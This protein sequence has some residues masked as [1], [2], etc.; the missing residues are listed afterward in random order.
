[1]H[2]HQSP[3][4]TTLVAGLA[5]LAITAGTWPRV[6]RSQQP[7]SPAPLTLAAARA[8]ARRASPD[9]R[10][11]REAVAA[12]A[13]RESQSAALPN[14]TLAYGREQTSRAGRTN[15]QDIGQLEQPLEVGGQRAA[16]RDAARLRRDA[17]EARL[18]AA[19]AQLDFDVARSYAAAVAAE[20]RA[21]LAEQAAGAFT[22]AE[23]VSDRRLAAGDLSGYAARRLRLE[24]A[25]YASLR[26]EAALARR[27]TRV[28]LASLLGAQADSLLLPAVLPDSAT[29][30]GRSRTLAEASLRDLALRSRP[31]LRASALEAA[32]AAAD[33][34]L[35]ARERIPS[36]TLSAGVK[37]E[38]V[39]DGGEGSGATF[40]GF[41][42][43]LSVPLPLFDRRRGAVQAAAAETRRRQAEADALRVRVARE[44]DEA[45]E[46]VRAI[47]VQ[48]EALRPQLGDQTR[49][50]MRAVQAAY[51]EGEITLVEWLDAVRAYQE[52]ES[53]Y[54]T[55]LA[56]AVVRRA[57]LE[58]A[59]GAS[60]TADG[61]S[62]AAAPKD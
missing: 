55:L 8:A 28:A 57:A 17:A 19:E 50:A 48:L 6:L 5:L 61:V 34:R 35:A 44:V 53:T 29:E 16:R 10:A 38:R 21:T 33:A 26:A 54:A 58:R 12:A 51:S 27:T 32:A 37:R 31:E 40:S 18:A 1:M 15:A 7:P 13:A 20:R 59:I 9:L 25:R 42:A 60:L 41:V 2:P 36:P 43:G 49:A 4:R 56:E 24:A 39:A 30:A 47:D 45:A 23:R 22:D 62:G 14:P 52:A 3:P 11:A 46:S